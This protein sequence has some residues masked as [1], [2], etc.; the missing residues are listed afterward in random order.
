MSDITYRAYKGEEEVQEVFKLI[1]DELSEPYGLFTYRYFMAVCPQH[2]LLAHCNGQL[3]GAIIG[4]ETKKDDGRVKGYIAMLVVLK[5]HRKKG[6]GKKLAVD[7]IEEMK[8]TCTEVVIET[9]VDN[10]PALRL[11]ES[12]GFVRTKRLFRYYLNGN[13]AY[14]L[15]IWFNRE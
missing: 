7:L 14:R 15:K 6:I 8:K 3:V 11:Y 10:F 1:D 13:E 5:E 9:E 4:R 12:L 2:C